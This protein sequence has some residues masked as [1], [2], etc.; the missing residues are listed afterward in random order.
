[1]KVIFVKQKIGYTNGVFDLLHTGHIDFFKQCKEYCDFLIVAVCP[2]EM[3]LHYKGKL[4]IIPFEERKKMLD[5]IDLINM[6]VDQ[7]SVN[8]IE[9]WNKYKFNVYFHGED[10]Y[11][12]DIKFGNYDQLIKHGIKVIYF[13]R[14]TSRSTTNIIKKIL[15]YYQNDK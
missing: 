1:M 5:H 14:D 7:T 2:D 6:V 15:D 11:E 12:F 9:E 4:P 10:G 13:P 8:R 3:V